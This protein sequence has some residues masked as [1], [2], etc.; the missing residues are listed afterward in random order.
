M[1][2]KLPENI[3]NK[4]VSLE[5]ERKALKDLT[6]SAYDENKDEKIKEELLIKLASKYTEIDT[7]IDMIK[8][9]YNLEDY[10]WIINLEDYTLVEKEPVEEDNENDEE[11]KEEKE[12]ESSI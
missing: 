11:Q 8:E 1:K 4:I 7:F 2:I 12:N 9:T 10:N 3:I 5:N 6:L